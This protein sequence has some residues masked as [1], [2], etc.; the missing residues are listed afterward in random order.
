MGDT[1]GLVCHLV[2]VCQVRYSRSITPRVVGPTRCG[3]YCDD[4]LIYGRDDI[5]HNGNLEGFM[6]RCKLKGIKLNRAKL[7]KQV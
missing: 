3:V 2:C 1:A 4:V 7:A 6:K 5:D